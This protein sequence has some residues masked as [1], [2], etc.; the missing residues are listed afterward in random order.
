MKPVE[1]YTEVFYITQ[2]GTGKQDGLSA[3]NAWAASDFN[4]SANWSNTSIADGK[5]GP[6]DFVG[7]VGT[8][9]T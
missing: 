8:I 3:S 9:R 5:T 1:A 4:D 6:N 7:L 2:A